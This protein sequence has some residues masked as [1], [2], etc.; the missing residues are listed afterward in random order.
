MIPI[1]HSTAD[2]IYLKIYLLV[3]DFQ[4]PAPTSSTNPTGAVVY[5]HTCYLQV[6]LWEEIDD[7]H[8]GLGSVYTRILKWQAVT[9]NRPEIQ[10]AG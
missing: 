7:P 9:Q 6:K 5:E 1:G 3:E 4:I 10:V 2:N 8:D